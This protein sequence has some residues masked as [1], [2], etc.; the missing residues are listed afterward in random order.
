[1]ADAVFGQM[2]PVAVILQKLYRFWIF[3]QAVS[4]EIR[5]LQIVLKNPFDVLRIVVSSLRNI[6]KLA[7]LLV[8]IM[9]QIPI[10]AVKSRQLGA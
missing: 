5:H 10:N 6:R 8:Q 4:D 9:F 2:E 1:M 3:N 7:N